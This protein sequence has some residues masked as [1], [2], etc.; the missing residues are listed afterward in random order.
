MLYQLSYT[1]IYGLI[2]YKRWWRMTGS[3]RRPPA[4]KAG[5]L[6]AELILHNGDPYG[7]RTR[8]TAVKGRC[9]NRLT[10]G[11]KLAP[12]VGFEP[13]TYRLT[14]G[15]STTELLR[16][17]LAWQ[18]PILTGGDPQLLSALKRLTSVFG[19]GTGVAASLSPP[20]KENINIVHRTCQ[21]PSGFVP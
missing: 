14:A 5:A 18:R 16:N 13:T 1:G 10:N 9:L 3:N 12:Q 6:P 4:C 17:D 8:V 7:I 21:S 11:P 2:D 20:D 19:M 15:C